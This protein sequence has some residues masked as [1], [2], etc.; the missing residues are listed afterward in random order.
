MRLVMSR[1][2]N[3]VI[4]M[5]MCSLIFMLSGCTYSINMAHTQGTA[6]DLIDETQSN[7]PNV[8]PNV[9]I[10]IRPY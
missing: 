1:E 4:L 3:L 8:S 9:S 10:P 2:M 7:E 5:V 6:T